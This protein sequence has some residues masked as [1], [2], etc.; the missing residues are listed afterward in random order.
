ME[1]TDEQPLSEADARNLRFLRVLVL[2]LTGTMIAGMVLLVALFYARLGGDAPAPEAL[3]VPERF[4]IPAGSEI[5]AVTQAKAFWVLV[6]TQGE[7]L[8]FAPTG[9][10]PTRTI[11][12]PD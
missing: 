5:A 7:V 11:P 3:V 10:A 1:P 12:A 4:E 2:V 8:F 9:G 6:T